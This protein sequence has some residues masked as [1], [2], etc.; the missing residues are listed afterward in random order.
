LNIYRYKTLYK[1]GDLDR[2]IELMWL[3]NTRIRATAVRQITS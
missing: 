1:N 3:L 2:I